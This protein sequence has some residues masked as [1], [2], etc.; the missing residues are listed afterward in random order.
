MYMYVIDNKLYSILIII[1]DSA[2]L[3]KFILQHTPFA[4]KICLI[5]S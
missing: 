1:S 4:N 2:I 3:Y 5:L